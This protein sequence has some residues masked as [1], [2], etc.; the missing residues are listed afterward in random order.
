MN[1]RFIFAILVALSLGACAFP[2]DDRD[3]NNRSQR[4]LEA[5]QARLVPILGLWTGTLTR[6]TQ[7]I[8]VEMLIAE[9]LAPTGGNNGA[10]DPILRAEPRATL[11]STTDARYP[12]QSFVG[13]YHEDTGLILLTSQDRVQGGFG[14]QGQGSGAQPGA[15]ASPDDLISM[16]LRYNGTT[17]Q[18]ILRA[19]GYI[20]GNMVLTKRAGPSSGSEQDSE[21][22]YNALLRRQYQSVEGNFYGNVVE[23]VGADKKT[24]GVCLNFFITDTA[25]ASGRFRPVLKAFYRRYDV[26]T[27]SL[28]RTLNVTYNINATP[29]TVFLTSRDSTVPGG[30]GGGTFTPYTVEI[31]AT[32]SDSNNQPTLRQ[33]TGT[34]TN[35]NL[36]QTGVLSMK[37][38]T[39]CPPPPQAGRPSQPNKPP[40]GRKPPRRK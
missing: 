33:L 5:T 10:G 17:I 29:S 40:P 30:G 28:R 24:F 15:A 20:V 11:Y 37:R 12:D 2:D 36:G 1:L 23:G 27:D 26:T 7:N 21:D 25:T 35:I 18:G 13:V 19:R 38:V 9:G 16:N 8:G 4:D 32:F 39:N 6:G 3:V 22:R 34:H 31:S 14:G